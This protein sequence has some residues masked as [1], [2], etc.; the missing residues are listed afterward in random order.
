MPFSRRKAKTSPGSGRQSACAAGGA[1]GGAAQAR[2]W[3]CCSSQAAAVQCSTPGGARSKPQQK[4]SQTQQGS[5]HPLHSHTGSTRAGSGCRWHS[6]HWPAAYY[7]AAKRLCHAAGRGVRSAAAAAAAPATTG[8]LLVKLPTL[9]T[10]SSR[11]Q[12]SSSGSSSALCPPAENVSC[13]HLMN[14]QAACAAGVERRCGA[15]LAACAVQQLRYG[16]PHPNATATCI[17]GSIAV[18]KVNRQQPESRQHRGGRLPSTAPEP[19][20]QRVVAAVGRQLLP[21]RPACSDGSG[22][23]FTMQAGWNQLHQAA[24]CSQRPSSAAPPRA[25]APLLD[26]RGAQL[27]GAVAQRRR[28][29]PRLQRLEVLLRGLPV[30]LR[31]GHGGCWGAGRCCCWRLSLRGVRP[32]VRPARLPLLLPVGGRVPR[33]GMQAHEASNR[34]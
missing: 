26:C 15:A 1:A 3:W 7:T 19:D 22:T 25:L 11:V 12:R 14:L 30:G 5:S 31:G 29:A 28:L 10:C 32:S 21:E 6:A 2:Q 16:M 17:R 18:N 34:R 9:P 20:L 4:C 24:A 27:G 33:A 13:V 23:G 8:L